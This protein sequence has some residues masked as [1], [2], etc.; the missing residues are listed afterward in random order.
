MKRFLFLLLFF[1][2]V[3]SLFSQT[4]EGVFNSAMGYK[5]VP[6]VTGGTS[7]SGVDCSGLTQN[8]YAENGVKL[9]RTVSSQASAGVA[10]DAANLK[11]GDLV[12]FA[13]GSSP[14]RPT[15]VAIYIG[16]NSIIHAISQGPKRGVNISK[17]SEP[18]WNPKI[19][20]YKRVF[21]E[22]VVV[23]ATDEPPETS[24]ESGDVPIENMGI[25]DKGKKSEQFDPETFILENP[26]K[27]YPLF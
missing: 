26:E 15:H 1:A 23:H 9:G 20:Y 16:K 13:T 18:Y 5:G 3:Y 7:K 11:P 24:V 25:V 12:F 22:K 14:T 2:S 17:L 19:L 21:E 6:Y 8:V 4:E 27:E 10:V